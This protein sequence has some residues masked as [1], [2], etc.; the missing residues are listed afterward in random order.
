MSSQ[1]QN[2][3]LGCLKRLSHHFLCAARAGVG[4]RNCPCGI[5]ARRRRL[6]ASAMACQRAQ[7]RGITEKP[8]V[9]RPVGCRAGAHVFRAGIVT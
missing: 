4:G 7:L 6:M 5:D 3:G 1:N 9:A 8:R 2:I